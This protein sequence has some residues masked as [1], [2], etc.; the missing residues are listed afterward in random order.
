MQDDKLII[1]VEQVR[2]LANGSLDGKSEA[3]VEQF[4]TELDF[5]AELFLKG[6]VA[7]K[8]AASKKK[9]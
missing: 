9:R 2:R 7:S 5:L 1:T 6:V 4:I 3:E 8:E